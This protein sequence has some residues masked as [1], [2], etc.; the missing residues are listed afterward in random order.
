MKVLTRSRLVCS[1]PS[2][3]AYVTACTLMN[4]GISEKFCSTIQIALARSGSSHGSTSATTTSKQSTQ[5]ALADPADRDRGRVQDQQQRDLT[6]TL[7]P[8]RPAHAEVVGQ[9]PEHEAE[10][11]IAGQP[12]IDVIPRALLEQH[13]LDQRVVAQ[14]RNA[15]ARIGEQPRVAQ[16]LHMIELRPRHARHHRRALGSRNLSEVIAVA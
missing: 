2:T 9:E 7:R 13:F 1:V 5:S 4:T 3:I 16:E 12:E 10:Q 8:G 14:Q 11:E 15:D 6:E